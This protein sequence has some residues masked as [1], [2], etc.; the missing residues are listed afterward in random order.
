MSLYHERRDIL[1]WGRIDRQPQSVASPRFVEDLPGLLRNRPEG[2]LLA[3]GR[4]RSYGDSIRNSLGSLILTPRLDRFL[5]FDATTGVL[6]AEAGCTLNDI[7]L[8]LVPKGW[9][10]PVTPGTRFVTLGGAVANDVHGKNHHRAGTFG[11]H[12]QRFSLLRSDG[13]RHV[14]SPGDGNG[15]FEATIGGLGLTGII[16]WVELKLQKIA[17]SDL[18]V[19][20]VPFANLQDFW[21]L[22]GESADSHEHTV[23]WIDCSGRGTSL[24]RGVFSRAN[25]C[26]DGPLKPHGTKVRLGMPVE[27]P[28]FTLNRM[29]VAAFNKVYYRA[30]ARKAGNS[31]QHYAQVFHPLDGIAEWNRLYGRRGFWQY[32]CVLPP[33]TMK[34]AT[35]SLL[36]EIS[37]SGEGSFL[38]VLKTFGDVPSP[39]MLSFPM[40]GSTLA[41]DFPNRGQATLALLARLDEIVSQAG[42]RLYA[43]KDGR[44][45]KD[46]WI[47]GYQR[48]P[49]FAGHVDPGLNSDFWR[50][51]SQ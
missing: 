7:M 34:G 5:S 36:D 33:G 15:L 35:A 46:L 44:L 40:E 31:R 47:S 9:F 1:S 12:V 13:T 3:V 8:R 39:G 14:L 37:K 28:S 42:G 22:A 29:T 21:N 19:E 50:R 17:S 16:E 32:Q 10:V 41:L 38:S 48:L 6:R 18:D 45:P 30:Q 43:A 26:Q 20:I 11:R 2:S 23:A 49:Q 25:W 51:V 27:A 24:G 4:C